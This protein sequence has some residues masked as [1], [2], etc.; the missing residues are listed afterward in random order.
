VIEKRPFPLSGASNQQ[1][2]GLAILRELIEEMRLEAKELEQS[3]D[4]NNPPDSPTA[5]RG[6]SCLLRG[7]GGD[8]RRMYRERGLRACG[9]QR[10]PAWIV[11]RRTLTRGETGTSLKELKAWLI[12][13]SPSSP[14]TQQ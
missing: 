13:L 6:G 14:R 3:N 1:N 4:P 2:L 7:E 12:L 11:I 10:K 8:E 5:E 9:C